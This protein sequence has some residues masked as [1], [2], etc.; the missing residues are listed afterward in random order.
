M[1]GNPEYAVIADAIRKGLKNVEKYYQ[2]AS[3][4]DIYF[5]CLVLDPNYK[6]AYVKRRWTGTKVA[7]GSARLQ[8][9]FDKYY[10]APLAP[11][12]HAKEPM[13]MSTSSSRALRIPYFTIG[14]DGRCCGMVGFTLAAVSNTSSCCTVGITLTLRRNALTPSTFSALQL[15]KAAYKNGHMSAAVE[16]EGYAAV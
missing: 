4:S 12:P 15:M 2:K 3:D 9:V 7:N 16:A 11:G 8:V 1:A 6:L 13:A 10:Q 14:G 5:I